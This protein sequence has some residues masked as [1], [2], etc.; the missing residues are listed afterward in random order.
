[1]AFESLCGVFTLR[2]G[3]RR[4]P[5]D[6]EMT[7]A[8]ANELV[9]VTTKSMIRSIDDDMRSVN[10]QQTSSVVAG[11]NYVTNLTNDDLNVPLP[12]E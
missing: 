11:A 6:Y 7:V 5:K 8:Q 1:M 4:R 3:I 2:D 10:A 9:E 12:N